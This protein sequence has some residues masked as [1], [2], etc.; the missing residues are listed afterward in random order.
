MLLDEIEVS[1][2][3]A[4]ARIFSAAWPAL[5]S[6]TERGDTDLSPAVSISSILED[7]GTTAVSLSTGLASLFYS[8]ANDCLGV[9]FVEQ[10]SF[11]FL[12]GHQRHADLLQIRADTRLVRVNGSSPTSDKRCGIISRQAILLLWQADWRNMVS[13]IQWCFS[14]ST[15]R[16][17]RL[18]ALH[19]QFRS[20]ISDE[21]Y[22]R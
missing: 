10:E 5:L 11:A 7:R 16:Y 14:A 15:R 17:R 3:F 1:G 2:N 22:I 18:A 12:L 21:G 4:V 8:D 19:D 9:I 20:R 6:Q 13:K